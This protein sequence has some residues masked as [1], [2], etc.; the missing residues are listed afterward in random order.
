MNED[1]APPS[2]PGSVAALWWGWI[3]PPA[4]WLAQFEIRYATV[5]WACHH[6]YRWLVLALGAAAFAIALLLTA[7]AWQCRS[8]GSG[9]PL[10]FLHAGGA[11]L[12]ALF[13]LVTLAQAL[14]DFFL[15]PCR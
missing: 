15:D 1:A 12:A 13:A 4:W 10:S 11:G 5:P 8:A 14:P 6:G 7:R 3:A 2:P 9:R